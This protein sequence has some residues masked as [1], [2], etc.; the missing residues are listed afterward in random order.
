MDSSLLNLLESEV[1]T[2]EKLGLLSQDGMDLTTVW[3]SRLNS[4]PKRFVNRDWSINEEALRD[5]RRLQIL[6]TDN[7]KHDYSK[8]SLKSIVSGGRRGERKMLRECISALTDRGYDRLLRKYPTHP[9]GNPI[10][11]A[12]KGFSYTHRWVKH[13]YFLG[14]INDVLGDKLESDFIALDVGS[15]YGIFSS[16]VKQE[17][18]SSHHVL[19]DFPEQLL[20]ARYFLSKCHPQAKIADITEVSD[21][22][23]LTRDWI[24][25]HDFVLIPCQLY[26][27]IGA[28]TVDLVTNFASFG[29]M[30]HKTY[31][32]YI[33]SPPIKTARY[34]FTANRI[35]SYPTYDTDMTILDYPIWEPQKRLHFGI[36]AA[37]CG[38]YKYPPK[39]R[40]FTVK[41]AIPPYFEYIG[42]V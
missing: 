21:L 3:R 15:S 24:Y 29:E 40:F 2:Y 28:E 18:P 6:V 27:R 16:L 17:Y 39:H 9:A 41:E 38:Y 4:E 42:V 7:P 30:P 12:Y 14:L 31:R 35:Q 13:I 1:K 32:R 25:D 20:L 34:F 23:T 10:S 22:A 11:F 5:F 36:C 19:V 26:E 37:F 8:F 33:E